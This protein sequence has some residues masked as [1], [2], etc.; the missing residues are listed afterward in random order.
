MSHFKGK[1][2]KIRAPPD[3]LVVFKGPILRTGRGKRKVRKRKKG[4]ET[5]GK[6]KEGRTILRTPCHKFRA[7]P[8][9][10]T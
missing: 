10:I 2:D 6:R 7:T 8:L 5:G 3:P 9:M 4:E 1:M